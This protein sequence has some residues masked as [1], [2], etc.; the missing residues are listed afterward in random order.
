M[1]INNQNEEKK[2]KGKWNSKMGNNKSTRN[3]DIHFKDPLTAQHELSMAITE[4]AGNFVV[5]VSYYEM[6]IKPRWKKSNWEKPIR[7]DG[8]VR[9]IERGWERHNRRHFLGL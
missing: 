4:D 3:E 1:K 5:V 7:E 8:R 9:E 2:Y 6:N